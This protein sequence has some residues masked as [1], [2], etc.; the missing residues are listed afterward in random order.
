[1][2]NAMADI[3]RYAVKDQVF[4]VKIMIYLKNLHKNEK[5]ANAF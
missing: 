2:R 3:S 1:M 5:S 4:Q